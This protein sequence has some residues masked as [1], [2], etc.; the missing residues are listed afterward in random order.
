MNKIILGLVMALLCGC[1]S[2]ISKQA[3]DT[4]SEVCTKNDGLK[5]IGITNLDVNVRVYC[6]NGS[7]FILM[8][9]KV[10]IAK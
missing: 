3:I 6:N 2:K 1:S 7:R 4:A 9:D 8:D 10:Y 5:S